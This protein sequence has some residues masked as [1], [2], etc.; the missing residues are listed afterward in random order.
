[1]EHVVDEMAS[2]GE[3]KR[4]LKSGGF[5]FIY[6]L[7]QRYAYTELINRW[8]SGRWHHPHRYTP[9]SIKI[10]LEAVGFRV[11][12]QRR[13]N[14]LPKNLTGLPPGA[15]RAYNSLG[16]LANSLDLGLSRVP[17]LNLL[18]HSIETIAEVEEV[19]RWA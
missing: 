10:E 8:R 11:L 4:V 12:G 15:R 6:Q 5:F 1:L 2:L 18:C 14:I 19:A 9:R 3:I 17:V 7:P 13:A 16:Y